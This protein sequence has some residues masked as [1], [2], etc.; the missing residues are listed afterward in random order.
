MAASDD[1]TK[2]NGPA[3]SSFLTDNVSNTP[4]TEEDP[5]LLPPLTA[6]LTRHP[7]PVQRLALFH[8][9]RQLERSIATLPKQLRG[10]FPT[11]DVARIYQTN[12]YVTS[13]VTP[14][15]LNNDFDQK[16]VHM[17]RQARATIAQL[18]PGEAILDLDDVLVHQPLVSLR[19]I[20][21]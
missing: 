21:T 19:L 2:A 7:I 1:R 5:D 15:G 14:M 9:G 18:G 20:D 12:Q 10:L 4:S 6:A 3:S 8:F 17:S 16:Y 13:G 11:A